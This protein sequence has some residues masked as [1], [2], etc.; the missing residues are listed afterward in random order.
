MIIISEFS[1]RRHLIW[2]ST[3]RVLLEQLGDWPN[4]A[5]WPL[6][7]GR[8]QNQLGGRRKPIYKFN[9]DNPNARNLSNFS[10]LDKIRRNILNI[11][12]RNLQC[13]LGLK[14]LRE[15][16]FVIR[17]KI[18]RPE[19]HSVVSLMKNSERIEIQNKS[20]ILGKNQNKEQAFYRKM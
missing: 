18:Y 11:S 15:L 2:L 14:N 9:F 20:W 17:L 19:G 5:D 16:H 6:W 4:Q 12:Y 7:K 1:T 3:N 8:K 13:F 10:I